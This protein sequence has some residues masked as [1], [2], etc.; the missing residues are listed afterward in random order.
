MHDVRSHGDARIALE[1]T[2]VAGESFAETRR[3]EPEPGD[4]PA[5]AEP[6]ATMRPRMTTTVPAAPINQLCPHCV[7]RAT[8]IIAAMR[9]VGPPAIDRPATRVATAS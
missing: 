1:R 7:S 3:D 8:E 9:P 2:G 5:V 4:R 6:R